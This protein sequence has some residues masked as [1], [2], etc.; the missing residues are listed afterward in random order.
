MFSDGSLTQEEIDALLQ[1]SGDVAIS[2]SSDSQSQSG[3]DRSLSKFDQIAEDAFGALRKALRSLLNSTSS[4]INRESSSITDIGRIHPL[5]GDES[6]QITRTTSNA[7][8]G[9]FVYLMSKESAL[10]LAAAIM[11]QSD[12][13][14]ND[15]VLNALKEGIAQLGEPLLTAI[16]NQLG[17]PIEIS[18]T[19]AR[20]LATLEANLPADPFI[21]QSYQIEL[22]GK[23]S[24]N[25]FELFNPALLEQMNVAPVVESATPSIEMPV[26]AGAAIASP[27]SAKASASP[28]IRSTASPPPL[29]SYAQPTQLRELSKDSPVSAEANLGLL[30]DVEMELTVELGRTRRLVKEILMMG[31]GSIV[32]LDKLAG[33][34]V[35]ILVNHRLIAKGEVVVIDENFGVRVTEIISPLER[36]R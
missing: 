5:L 1:S 22:K 2:E 35:D 34:S 31:E 15:A 33:E 17:T 19:E 23:K 7:A 4:V 6:V 16:G 21:L 27:K 30:M 12:L 25:Y 26:L 29:R 24:I 20:S 13:E 3:V 36:F 9:E 8:I 14:L 18:A 11:N 28:S 10:I 32:E